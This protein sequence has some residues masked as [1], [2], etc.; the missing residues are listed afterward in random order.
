VGAS[1]PTP[2]RVGVFGGTFDPF[3]NGHL[4]S[5]LA[6]VDALR[7]DR[8]LV[9]VANEP[10][11]KE[12]VRSLTPA[13]DRYAMVEAG[14][15]GHPRLVPCRLEIERGG[16]SYTV[17]TLAELRRLGPPSDLYLVVGADVVGDLA[18]WRDEPRLRGMAVL[19]VVA[20][21]GAE[22][23]GIPPGWQ[24]VEVP[25]VPLDIS[26]TDLRRRLEAGEPVDGLVP[27][28]VV[29]CIRHRGLYA[30]GR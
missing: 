25:A 14:T 27:P 7:L 18:T 13:E 16:P 28:A 29:R 12:W 21:P 19:A 30:T 22:R 4:A 1:P 8:L 5:A 17:D 2:E 6:V 24:A 3:H 20:R 23:V 10:W 9:M 26:G 15:S 11:Q